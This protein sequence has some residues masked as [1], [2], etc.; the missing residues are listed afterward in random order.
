MIE[1]T[2]LY[3]LRLGDHEAFILGTETDDIAAFEKVNKA[4]IRL[5]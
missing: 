5:R 2:K 1:Y 3:A 4:I